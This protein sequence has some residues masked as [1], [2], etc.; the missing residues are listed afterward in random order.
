MEKLVDFF[1]YE[2][3]RVLVVGT[4]VDPFFIFNVLD[5]SQNGGR[6]LGRRLDIFNAFGI[7][8]A[9]LLI[10]DAKAERMIRPDPFVLPDQVL[11]NGTVPIESQN[12]RFHQ[13]MELS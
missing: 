12:N 7:R 3:D 4:P 11:G 1:Y 5:Q 8:T 13:R 2:M 9:E 10:G 6:D